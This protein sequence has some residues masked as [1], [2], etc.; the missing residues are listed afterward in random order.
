VNLVVGTK[1][2]RPYAQPLDESSNIP[3]ME[4]RRLHSDVAPQREERVSE[5]VD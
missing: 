2:G 5:E 3:S 4:D 1:T